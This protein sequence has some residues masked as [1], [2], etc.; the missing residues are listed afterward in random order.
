MAPP[1]FAAAAAAAA[2]EGRESR[3]I[4]EGSGF[5]GFCQ[6]RGREETRR[7]IDSGVQ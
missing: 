5:G 2:M 4:G 6:L 7:L 3:W 1:P